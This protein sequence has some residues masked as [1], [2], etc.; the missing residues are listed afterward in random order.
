MADTTRA[1]LPFGVKIG[2]CSGQLVEG[3]VNNV[4]SVFLLF[5]VT[6]A[7]GLEG[8]LAGIALS[9]GLI[10]DAVMDPL[11]GSLS[12]GWRSRIGRRLPFMIAGL[13]PMVICFVLV[14]S[15]PS[16]LGQVGLAIWVA[17][18]LIVMR[19]SMSLFVLPYQALSAELSDDYKERSSLMSWRWGLGQIGALLVMILGFSVF[20][21][22]GLA[23]RGHYIPFALALAAIFTAGALVAI[24][25]TWITRDRQRE[26]APAEGALGV[27][28]FRELVEV[29]RNP[30][31]RILF[32]GA[33]LLF[34]AIGVYAALSI[35][36]N[37]FFWKLTADQ[38]QIVTL[39]LFVGLLVGAPLAGPLLA[40]FEKATVLVI[41]MLGLGLAMGAPTLL[42]FAGL[43]PLTGDALSWTLATIMLTGGALMA[44]AAIAFMAMIADA[45]DEHEYLFGARRE[46][47]FFAGWAFASKAA[48]GIG[49]LVSGAVLQF[50]HFPTDLAQHGGLQAVLP[51]AMT[52]QLALFTGPG[53]GVLAIAA[54]LLNLAYR[55]DREKHAAIL[56]ALAVRHGAAPAE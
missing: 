49:A 45:A 10:I 16:G 19:I 18:L 2:Y 52:D 25:M 35:H 29:F 23:N 43:L 5:Y 40:W 8:G 50:I 22:N 53:T 41:G 54:A 9:I 46:G 20:L 42:R 30:S 55:L 34:V 12:D 3:V 14:F 33:I 13:V 37:T 56:Q 48:T 15:L 51:T 26:P 7:C 1:P 17:S 21:K 31:F 47:L 44:A 27:R 4:L 6:T 39:G 28:V 36:T 32:F 38:T 11:I 24:R